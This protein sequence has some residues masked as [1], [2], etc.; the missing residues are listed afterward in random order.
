MFIIVFDFIVIGFIASV[1]TIEF[2]PMMLGGIACAIVLSVFDGNS[3][4]Y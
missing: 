2:V 3:R 1:T 4:W